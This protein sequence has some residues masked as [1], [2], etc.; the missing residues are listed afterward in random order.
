MNDRKWS[1]RY[2]GWGYLQRGYDNTQ[3]YE[4]A[5]RMHREWERVNDQIRS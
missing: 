4:Q 1:D 2:D 3:L 5:Q